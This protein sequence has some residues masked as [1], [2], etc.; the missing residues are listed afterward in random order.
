MHVHIHHA[1]WQIQMQHTGGEF[2]CHDLVPVGFLQCGDQ[3]TGFDRPSVDEKGLQAAAGAGVAWLG[4][5]AGE[6]ILLPAAVNP[7]HAGT[8]SAVDA[9]NCIGK[10]AAA[11]GVQNFL[12]VAQHPEGNAGMCQRLQLHGGSDTAA[13]DRVGLHK[14]HA[15][16]GVEKQV[17][18]D[19]GGTVGAACLRFLHDF[20]RFQLKAYT[21]NGR[22]HLG[23]QIDAADGGNGG[24]GFAAETA[25]GDGSQVFGGTQ[26][27]SCVAQKGGFRIFQRHAAAVVGHPQEGHAAVTDLNGDFGGTGIHRIFQQFLCNGGGALHHLTGGDQIGHMGG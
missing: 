6:G 3:Q 12:A 27:G 2:A 23:Q 13:L 26:F 24:Q 4:H 7:C 5:K 8:F 11:G 14:L 17:P 15:G 21:F 10:L 16:G 25:G 9:V 22:G 19:D 20:P 1:R 18:D